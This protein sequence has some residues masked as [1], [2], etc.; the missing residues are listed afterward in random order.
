M[1]TLFIIDDDTERAEKTVEDALVCGFAPISVT[2]EEMAYKLMGLLTPHAAVVDA[3]L[4]RRYERE[5]LR[6]IQ[7]LRNR[8]QDCFTVCVS[9]EQ[10]TTELGADA[11]QH[12][13]WNFVD[14]SWI[15]IYGRNV[16]IEYMKIMREM[17]RKQDQ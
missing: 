7:A 4:T 8:H 5:G 12:G 17:L 1:P 16:L 3:N 14:Y 6:V 2:S 10:G 9:S 11:M 13:A 15:G